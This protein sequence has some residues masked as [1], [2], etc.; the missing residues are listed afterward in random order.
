MKNVKIEIVGNR[1]YATGNTYHIKDAIKKAGGKWD[2]EKKGWYVSASKEEALKKAIAN[3]V[4]N[5]EEKS[6][7][8]RCK[9]CGGVIKDAPEHRA[10]GGYC[11]ECAFDEF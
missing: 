5:H 7:G 11:G 1:A 10:V 4:P 9:S 8:G 6:N 2:S 3:A